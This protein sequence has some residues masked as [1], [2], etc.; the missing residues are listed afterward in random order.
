WDVKGGFQNVVGK[1]VKE[2]MGRTKEGHRWVEWMDKFLRAREFMITWDGKDRGMG[3][4]NVGV[5]QGSPLSPVV[6]LI[7]MAPILEEMERRVREVTGVDIKLPSYVDDI[8][9]GI[10]DWSGRGREEEGLEGHEEDLLARASTV[11]KEVAEE[12]GLPLEDSKE[13]KLI[14]KRRNQRRGG[15]KKKWVKW[16]GIILDEDLEFDV[17]WKQRIEKARKMLGAL[18]GIGNFQ[19]GISTNSWRSAYTGMIWTIASWGAEIGWRGQKEWRNEM[20]RLQYAAL[21]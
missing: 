6:F 8:H 21:R 16:L 5:P 12:F 2:Y 17:Y 7:W 1:Q 13:E 20:C 4:T 19:W 14:L 9:L 3:R 18:N 15:K 11:V 10:Y